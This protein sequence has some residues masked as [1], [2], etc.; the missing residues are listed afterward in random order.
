MNWLDDLLKNKKALPILSFPMIQLWDTTLNQY[1]HDSHLQALGMQEI[2]KRY[3]TAAVCSPMDL[4]VEAECFGSKVCFN[5]DEMPNVIGSIVSNE[6]EADD[7]KIPHVGEARTQIYIDGVKE[8]L[9]LI[10]DCPV[11]AGMIGPFS[12]AGR[13]M[14]V[15]TAMMY[16]YD[17]PNMVHKVLEKTTQFIIEYGKAYKAIGAHGVIIAEPLAGVLSPAL[18]KEFSHD[19][20][21]KIVD[22]LKNDHFVVIYH[23]CGN[24]TI[25]MLEDLF[26]INANAYHFGNAIDIKEVLKQSGHHIIMGNI[27]PVGVL[28]EDTAENV[29]QKTMTLLKQTENEKNF[30]V[31]SGCDIPHTTPLENIEAF[32]K[33]SQDFYE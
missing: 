7:L 5:E 32:M 19:Y 8:A 31:S 24:N 29:Y 28:K 21:K 11:L 26:K 15:T 25:F 18:A 22:E 9:S 27:D 30:I 16:C 3:H 1:V 2:S 14:D 12:L 13:L 10:E 17:M 33:A 23:N 20:V 6:K 4:S